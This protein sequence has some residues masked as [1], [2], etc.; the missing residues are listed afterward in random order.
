MSGQ[1]QITYELNIIPG[2]AAELR[3]IAK[4]MVAFNDEGEPG[5]LRYNVYMNEGETLFTF[6]EIF[7]DSEKCSFHGERFAGGQFV[8]QVLERTDGGRLC[9]FGSAS[10]DFKNWAAEAGFEIEYFDFIDGFVR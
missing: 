3:E 9:V 4:E 1:I 6:L 2:K 7:G 5:T 8:G 10:Q